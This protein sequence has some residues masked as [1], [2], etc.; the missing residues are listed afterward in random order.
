MGKLLTESEA[1]DIVGTYSK[2]VTTGS[3]FARIVDDLRPD[4]KCLERAVIYS[5][6][7]SDSLTGPN[8]YVEDIQDESRIPLRIMHRSSG[9]STHDV[10]RGEVPFK[11]QV[12]AINHDYM[13]N[14]TKDVLGNSQL[15]IPGLEP[16]ST[17]IVAEDIDML[18]LEMVNR[19]FMAESSTSTPSTSI[20]WRGGGNFAAT[21]CLTGSRQTTGCHILWTRRPRKASMTVRSPRK[22][23][24]LLEFALPTS[25]K[26]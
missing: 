18:D 1:R 17:L 5:G 19:W 9:I 25:T 15:E 7:V 2:A 23:Y 20:I 24:M 16:T 13:H 6:K 4:Y 8:L 11:D 10:K 3:P 22:N 21:S 26:K 12:L 14:L